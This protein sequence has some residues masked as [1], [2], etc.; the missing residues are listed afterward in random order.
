M[1]IFLILGL[2][3]LLGCLVLSKKS[4]KCQRSDF[5]Y[6][7][8]SLKVLCHYE[9][10]FRNSGKCWCKTVQRSCEP[11]VQATTEGRISMKD[12][13]SNQRFTVTMQNL[14]QEDIGRYSCGIMHNR[15]CYK[16]CTFIVSLPPGTASPEGRLPDLSPFTE[17]DVTW[18]S[19][20]E[21]SSE[22]EGTAISTLPGDSAGTEISLTDPLL[23]LKHKS[24]TSKWLVKS[25]KMTQNDENDIFV[26]YSMF[27]L[28]PIQVF[29]YKHIWDC[30]YTCTGSRL[31][32]P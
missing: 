27:N 26:D 10:K 3:P 28:D 7:G 9:N 20:E 19:S 11:L 29:E 23:P 25:I 17:S 12:E 22:E 32:I 2:M 8:D 5:S 31:N 18:N 24:N 13:Y 1:K 15:Y 14:T 21:D 6:E 30:V 4:P 16:M